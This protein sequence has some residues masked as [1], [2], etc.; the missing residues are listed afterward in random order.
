VTSALIQF[1]QG[2]NTGSAGNAVFGTLTDGAVTCVSGTTVDVTDPA[3]TQVS[4]PPL[5]DTNPVT[6]NSWTFALLDVPPTS[7][8]PLGNFGGTSTSSFSQPDARG[9]Y[10]VQVT[11]SDG[12]RAF[13]STNTLQVKEVS[14]RYIPPFSAV[15]TALKFSGNARGWA[16]S[17]EAWLRYL[18]S[19]PVPA[20]TI[21]SFGATTSLIETGNSIV[22]PG[23]TASFSA[24]PQT[25]VLTNNS[26]SEAKDVHTT[27][28]AFS[29]SHTFAF[30][31]PNLTITFTIT[32]T[33]PPS[34]SPSP[35][36]AGIISGQRTFAAV[37]PTGSSLATLIAAATFTS[38]LTARGF[39]FTVTGTGGTSR[40]QWAYPSRYGTPA[41]VKDNSTGFGVAYTFLGA[42][43]RTNAF[44][45]VENY[46][47]Y[48]TVSSFTGSLTV[49]VT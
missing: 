45:Y 22:N 42:F 14:G 13:A 17:M 44:G 15:D 26:D 24:T 47:Q 40:A 20:L 34:P 10:L 6:I 7:A 11:V 5:T 37:V 8:I 39:S 4:G 27:P 9:G 28:T 31:T 49:V 41:T 36:S 30:P 2:V 33:N 21:N 23:F 25:L 32:A 29:S 35:R 38:V 43:S 19:L 3:W 12:V 46:N 16:P 48:E 1:T 18:D